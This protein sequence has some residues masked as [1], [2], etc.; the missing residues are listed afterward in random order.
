MNNGQFPG[1]PGGQNNGRDPRQMLPPGSNQLP[2]TTAP[3]DDDSES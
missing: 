2:P 3:Q 1:G